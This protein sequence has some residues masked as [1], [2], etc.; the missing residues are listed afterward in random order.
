MMI[1]IIIRAP[2]MPPTIPP[3]APPDKP[4]EDGDVLEGE[5]GESVKSAEEA[6][7]ELPV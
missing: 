6:R 7:D 2:R 3:I 1:V 4:D 5:A